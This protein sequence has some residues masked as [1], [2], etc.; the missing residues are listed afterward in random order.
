MSWMCLP[1]DPRV[2]KGVKE[3][4]FSPGVTQLFHSRGLLAQCPLS[5]NGDYSSNKPNWQ[6]IPS[7]DAFPSQAVRAP[8]FMFPSTY[9]SPAAQSAH[10]C[11]NVSG[12][13]QKTARGWCWVGAI[14]L[15]RPCLQLAGSWGGQLT[16]CR[17]ECRFEEWRQAQQIPVMVVIYL[18]QAHINDN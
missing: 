6:L 1:V 12:A 8:A 2:S 13:M 7:Q 5:T 9:T 4:D 16:V 3:P 17:S 10:V 15:G 14:G 11:G 18:W